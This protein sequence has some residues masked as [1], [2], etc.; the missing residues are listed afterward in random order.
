M[1]YQKLNFQFMEKIVASF[2]KKL[3]E[4]IVNV[5]LIACTEK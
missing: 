2:C 4:M 3:N 1:L 5:D